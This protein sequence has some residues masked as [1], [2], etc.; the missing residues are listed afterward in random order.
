MA[1][2]VLNHLAAI[3]LFSGPL[4]YAG[5]FLAACPER[6]ARLPGL[7]ARAFRKGPRTL[8]V[9]ASAE[10]PAGLRWGL[11]AAGVTLVLLAIAI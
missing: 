9:A 11:R 6:A 1:G 5:L 10:I 4:F 3:L 2:M 7:L 8:G